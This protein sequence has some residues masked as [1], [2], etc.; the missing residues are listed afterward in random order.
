MLTYDYNSSGT[1]KNVVLRWEDQDCQQPWMK[2]ILELYDVFSVA[3]V[4]GKKIHRVKE[5]SYS[6]KQRMEIAETID[7]KYRLKKGKDYFYTK[8]FQEYFD[9]L[10]R[11]IQSGD[12]A[13]KNDIEF[14]EI[15]IVLQSVGFNNS[16]ERRL[17]ELQRRN[18][19][20][21]AKHAYAADF[22]VP[23]AGKST[24]ALAFF[25]YKAHRISNLNPA[26]KKNILLVISPKAAFTSWDEQLEECL[27]GS[28]IAGAFFV[29][30]EGGINNIKL[31]ISRVET[32][33][34]RF[35]YLIIGYNQLIGNG[36]IEEINR[37]VKDNLVHIVIDESHRIKKDDGSWSQACIKIGRDAQSRLILSGTPLPRAVTDL[38][39]QYQFLK[40]YETLNETNII[41]KIE[42]YFIR[43]TSRELGLPEPVT[44]VHRVALSESHQ[45][46]YNLMMRNV[47]EDW[48]KLNR[49]D[50]SALNSIRRS[51]M[52]LIMFTSNPSL[53]MKRVLEWPEDGEASK[54]YRD[55][56]ND[57]DGGSKTKYLV[58]QLTKIFEKDDYSKVIIW[59]SFRN[60]VKTINELCNYIKPGCSDYIHRDMQQGTDSFEDNSRSE[61]LNRFSREQEFRV[62][63]ANPS[64]LGESVSLHRVCRHAIYLDRTFNAGQYIQSRNR[65]HRL[66]LDPNIKTNIDIYIAEATI[67]EFINGQ[68]VDRINTM[69]TILN[70]PSLSEVL[71]LPDEPESGHSKDDTDD[72]NESITTEIL[73]DFFKKE[74]LKS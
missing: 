26:L 39:P 18:I 51:V 67:D 40:P 62:L 58:K 52:S 53:I 2:K 48:K 57:L 69:G 7:T 43:T 71:E 16:P 30:L 66:G 47:I 72:I 15:E 70:D 37:F 56:L 25:H 68:I 36:V 55:I 34:E 31:R 24:V 59:T 8:A 65:I 73:E 27:P 6:I 35:V 20:F 14:S 46:F 5:E 28:Q 1:E 29:R 21:L 49:Q 22:S 19:C 45:N 50:R 4:L 33:N 23:G 17:T 10:Q 41:K 13:K 64:L 42:P 38:I 63:V 54:L 74:M 60:N 12:T 11:S 44:Q 61:L 32:S 9:N 3:E